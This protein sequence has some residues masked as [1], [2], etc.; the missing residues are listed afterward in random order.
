MKLEIGADPY[1]GF[2]RR[3]PRSEEL[4]RRAFCYALALSSSPATPT[5]TVRSLNGSL[6]ERAS[7]VLPFART[8]RQFI[9]RRPGFID[10]DPSR[11]LIG[12][13]GGHDAIAFAESLGELRLGSTTMVDSPHVRLLQ[14]A[15]E[16]SSSL[17]DAEIRASDYW[18]FGHS[19]A[20]IDGAWFGANDDDEFLTVTRNFIDWTLERAPRVTSSAGSPFDDHILVARVNG[21]P[22]LQVIDGHH[23]VAAAIVRGE[24][25]LRVNRT[26]LNVETPLQRRLHQLNVTRQGADALEQPLPSPDVAS[27]TTTSDCASRL[28]RMVQFLG[29][30]ASSAVTQRSFLDVS[31]SYGWYLAEMKKFGFVVRGI[32]TDDGASG[33]GRSFLGLRPEELVVGSL[34]ESLEGLTETSDVVA[35]FRLPEL[36]DA[37]RDVGRLA[38]A[39]DRVVDHVLFVD[40]DE[41][42]EGAPGGAPPR[43]G[44]LT[45][46]LL[47]NTSFQ[48]VVDLGENHD[49]VGGRRT[50]R[51]VAF[52]RED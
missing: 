47:D 40:V 16:H 41:H 20:A 18:A 46:L 23:R 21:S 35:C 7:R 3:L 14:A 52:V 1:S 8:L 34:T 15:M 51:L 49:P 33:I 42:P 30:E 24:T 45:R 12:A 25:S 28:L 36:F 27:W 50:T 39:I 44:T 19:V 2:W 11:L 5:T 29:A 9:R 22:M 10:V 31:S 37:G 17:T 48:R 38:K 13:Q 26:W 43:V 4:R 32:E 6:A